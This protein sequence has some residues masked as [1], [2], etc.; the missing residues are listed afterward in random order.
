MENLLERITI[1]PEVCH[2]KPTVRNM[3][4]PAEMILDLLSSGM[5]FQDISDDFPKIEEDDVKAVLIFASK[6]NF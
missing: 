5:S 1:N 3:R 2:G 6:L 4:Y